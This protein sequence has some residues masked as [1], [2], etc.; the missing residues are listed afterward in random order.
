[1]LNKEEV[2]LSKA[3]TSYLAQVHVLVGT[4][5]ALA[6]VAAGGTEWVERWD[7]VGGQVGQSGWTGGTGWM[8][9]WDGVA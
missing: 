4:P 1:M 6:E 5:A 7:R 9:R 3:N 8:D 2:V